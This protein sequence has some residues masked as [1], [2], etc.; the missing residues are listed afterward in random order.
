MSVSM[1]PAKT[2]A[3]CLPLDL[4]WIRTPSVLRER[5]VFRSAIGRVEW[6]DEPAHHGEHVRDRAAAFLASTGA[7][8]RTMRSMAKNY[9]Q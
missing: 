7:M 1:N 9:R 2:A 8:A 3:A 5:R 6:I 4:S